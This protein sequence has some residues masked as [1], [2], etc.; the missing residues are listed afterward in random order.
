[1]H[2]KTF[3]IYCVAI[4]Y[5]ANWPLQK[6]LWHTT[7]PRCGRQSWCRLSSHRWGLS[8]SWNP[9]G[10]L[11]WWRNCHQLLHTPY[12]MERVETM[13]GCR[14]WYD[15]LF[16]QEKPTIIS[17]KSRTI[18]RQTSYLRKQWL[19]LWHQPQLLEMPRM[20]IPDSTHSN[21]QTRSSTSSH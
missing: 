1:M 5:L 12:L 10:C 13:E 20:S 21:H 2:K 8:C 4:L 6:T 18:S 3:L 11:P 19:W 7:C 16:T 17:F 15:A 14:Y 9:A